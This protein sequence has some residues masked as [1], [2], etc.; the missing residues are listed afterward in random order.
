MELIYRIDS[1]RVDLSQGAR[2]PASKLSFNE[3]HGSI[4]V[5]FASLASDRFAMSVYRK[6][7]T[8]NV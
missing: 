7:L 4:L 2:I 3:S 5:G 8:R 1:D 6:A